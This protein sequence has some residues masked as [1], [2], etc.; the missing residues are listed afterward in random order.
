M[1]GLQIEEREKQC[2]EILSQVQGTN[3]PAYIVPLTLGDVNPKELTSLGPNVDC[4][5]D[6]QVTKLFISLPDLSS[7]LDM[8]QRLR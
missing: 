1:L 6:S 4:T 2:Q 5:E 3:I 7:K 8:L